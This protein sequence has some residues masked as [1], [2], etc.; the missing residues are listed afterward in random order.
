MRPPAP[1]PPEALA[2]NLISAQAHLVVKSTYLR[3]QEELV[4]LPTM[5][6]SAG[7]LYKPLEPL[8]GR[9][10][11]NDIASG[12][13]DFFFTRYERFKLEFCEAAHIALSE[14]QRP[15]RQDPHIGRLENFKSIAPAFIPLPIAPVPRPEPPRAPILHFGL[16]AATAAS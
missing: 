9:S 14:S 15:Y 16:V 5:G 12:V 7:E 11:A 6:I 8:L 2:G 4:E 3:A 10:R 13:H 1:A